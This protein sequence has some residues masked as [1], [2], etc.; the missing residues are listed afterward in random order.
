[1]HDKKRQFDVASL[2]K[3]IY[4]CDVGGKQMRYTTNQFIV[5]LKVLSRVGLGLD[6][7]SPP[8]LIHCCISFPL[9]RRENTPSQNCAEWRGGTIKARRKRSSCAKRVS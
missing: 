7:N 6:I 8:Y 2:V 3:E 5:L 1:M 9:S 4:S